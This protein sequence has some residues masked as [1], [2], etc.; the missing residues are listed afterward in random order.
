MRSWRVSSTTTKTREPARSRSPARRQMID[1]V[2]H[3]AR[4]TVASLGETL[5]YRECA[6]RH[7]SCHIL[8]W[9]LSARIPQL[10]AIWLRA[11]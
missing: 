1:G 3:G 5:H 2:H 7:L 4:A 10:D 9:L 8:P 11:L 6:E